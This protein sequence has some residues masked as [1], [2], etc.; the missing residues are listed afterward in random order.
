MRRASPVG[1]VI[2]HAAVQRDFLAAGDDLQPR[3]VLEIRWPANRHGLWIILWI[4]L[5]GSEMFPP[6]Q[7]QQQT[8]TGRMHEFP[9]PACVFFVYPMLLL[10]C[11]CCC[12][13]Y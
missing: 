10:A 13:L 12:F 2:G 8:T 9:A 6:Q 7:Q 5:C 3:C 11:C 1:R 4:S